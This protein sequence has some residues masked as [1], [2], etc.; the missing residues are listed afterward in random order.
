VKQGRER[1][2]G[3]RKGGKVDYLPTIDEFNKEEKQLTLTVSIFLYL[4]SS[5]RIFYEITE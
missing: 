2:G 5:D 3:S 4:I 1:E